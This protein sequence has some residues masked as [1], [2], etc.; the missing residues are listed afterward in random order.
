MLSLPVVVE[1]RHLGF[2]ITDEKGTH[3]STMD[4]SCDRNS[5]MLEPTCLLYV[6][7]LALRHLLLSRGVI[8]PEDID[9]QNLVPHVVVRASKTDGLSKFK[10]IHGDKFLIEESMLSPKSDFLIVELDKRRGLHYTI[11][12]SKKLKDRV[13]SAEA[14]KETI[15][16]LNRYPELLKGYSSLPYFGLDAIPYWVETADKYPFN[17]IPP[18]DWK[19]TVKPKKGEELA[20]LKLTAAGSVIS[21]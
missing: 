15:M 21:L 5:V 4:E 17:V 14:F 6:Y 7:K 1:V 11:I 2:W 12:F 19:P 20:K 16:T 10:T 13:D 8:V 18:P 9:A 3:I